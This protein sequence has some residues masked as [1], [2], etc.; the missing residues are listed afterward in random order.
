MLVHPEIGRI[1]HRPQHTQ[2]PGGYR[3]V[4]I[5]LAS[6]AEL[7]DLPLGPFPSWSGQANGERV[8]LPTGGELCGTGG[9]VPPSL[10]STRPQENCL[11]WGEFEPAGVILHPPIQIPLTSLSDPR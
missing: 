3:G 5:A 8:S 10:S 6:K 2:S 1:L 7:L 9:Q 4:C 11:G